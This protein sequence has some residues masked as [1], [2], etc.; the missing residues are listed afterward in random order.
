MKKRDWFVDAGAFT[1]TAVLAVLFAGISW[2]TV[3]SCTKQQRAIVRTVVDIVDQVCG[4][5]DNVDECLGKAQAARAAA[6]AAAAQDAGS[7]DASTD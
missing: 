5:Q 7:A 3:A 1:A 4:D 6:R 2:S